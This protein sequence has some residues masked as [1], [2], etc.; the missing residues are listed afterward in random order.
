VGKQRRDLAPHGHIEQ[1]RPHLG[2][3][4]EPLPAKAIRIRPKAAGVGV[5][6]RLPF[7]RARAQAFPIVGLAPVL[8]LDQAL[9]QIEGTPL[10][11]PR[12]TALLLPWCLDRGKHLGVYKR[13]NWES[14]PVFWGDI[15][16]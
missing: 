10:G 7:A 12:M 6:P 9:E 14:K 3:L 4:T 1:I 5:R 13:G 2:R 15:H 16:G 11:L 8:T